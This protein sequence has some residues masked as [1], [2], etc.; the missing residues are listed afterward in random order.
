MGRGSGNTCKLPQTYLLRGTATH[1]GCCCQS[2]WGQRLICSTDF[3]TVFRHFVKT[4]Y[5]TNNW[6]VSPPPGVSASS[7]VSPEAFGGYCCIACSEGGPHGPRRERAASAASVALAVVG[8]TRKP[9]GSFVTFSR[10]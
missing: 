4:K 6:V 8:G 3:H 9:S 2:S 1:S 7:P 10:A 5:R